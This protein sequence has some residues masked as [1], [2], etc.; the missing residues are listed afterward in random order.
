MIR[1]TFVFI[2]RVAWSKTV[3]DSSELPDLAQALERSGDEAESRIEASPVMQH[4][5][6]SRRV[7]SH[8]RRL[9]EYVCSRHNFYELAAALS[10]NT[11]HEASRIKGLESFQGHLIYRLN[12]TFVAGREG[13]LTHV[14]GGL[15]CQIE[16]NDSCGEQV[17]QVNAPQSYLP[18]ALIGARTWRNS[19]L[20][21]HR[22]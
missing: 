14:S 15:H 11:W 4:P 18:T 6:G 21:T 3:L 7:V 8:D 17:W 9:T 19:P 10:A 13:V 12:Q 2:E 22:A 5:Q 16:L 1:R 20:A